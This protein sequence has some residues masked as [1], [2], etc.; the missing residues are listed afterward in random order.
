METNPTAKNIHQSALFKMLP[1]LLIM[2]FYCLDYFYRISTGLIVP[3][4]MTHYSVTPAGIGFF[5]SAFYLGYVL[6]QIPGGYLIDKLPLQKTIAVFIVI[7]SLTFLGFIYS[8]HFYMGVL[9]RFLL[10]LASALSFVSVLHVA[11]H[12]LNPRYFGLISGL[13]IA[14]GTLTGSLI[15]VYIA[16]AIQYWSWQTCLALSALPSLSIA[17]LFLLPFFKSVDTPLISAKTKPIQLIPSIVQ[18][19]KQRGFIL[20]A[21]IGG[22]FYLPT[23]ILAAAWGVSLFAL[24]YHLSRTDSAFCITLLF[25]GWSLGS[26]IIG[27]LNDYFFNYRLTILICALAAA[28]VSIVMIILPQWVHHGVYMLAFLVG[29]FSSAQVSVWNIFNKLCPPHINGIGIALTNMIITL[30]AALFHIVEGFLI[31]YYST[32]KSHN[33]LSNTGLLHGLW[34]IPGLFMISALLSQFLPQPVPKSKPII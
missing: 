34:I 1:I 4:L 8:H 23:S 31:T 15:Q 11:R 24:S 9:W 16:H 10:G 2:G 12:T 14:V 17:F 33:N 21:I 28:M 27:Y 25:A 26:P 29:L 30:C 32:I 6:F 7:C 3:E 19:S 18:L 22:L 20:N 13:T 5:A